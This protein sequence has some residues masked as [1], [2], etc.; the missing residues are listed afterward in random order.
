MMNYKMIIAYDG[1]RYKGFKKTKAYDDL[2]I[3]GK[4]ETLLFKRYKQ[5]IEVI[6]AV[7]TDAGVHAHEQLINFKVPETENKASEILAYCEQYLPDDIVIL[8]IEKVDERFHSR[9]LTKS[10]TYQYRLW[11]KDAINRPLFERHY[12]N[13]MKE[14][15]DVQLMQ[16]AASLLVGEHDFIAFTTR[17][18]VKN[19]VKNLMELNVEETDHEIL[20][21]MT[22][23]SFLVNMERLIV[24]TLIQIGSGQR[25]IDCVQ[26]AFES[27]DRENVGHKAM[28]EA[29]SL[30]KVNYG[31][32]VK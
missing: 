27:K 1:R 26:R 12:V 19:S 18:K 32:V 25:K 4:F 31:A 11:K 9:Y 22:A 5:S 16:K 3:Q 23:N 28:A 15:L 10:V 13:V 8:S 21:T 2:T 7:N 24:G 20:I 6:S 14:V 29:M 17:N 30:V